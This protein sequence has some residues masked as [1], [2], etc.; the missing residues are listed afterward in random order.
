[1]AQAVM[2]AIEGTV[3]QLYSRSYRAWML[4][5]L[6][7][8]NALNLADRQCMAAV[9][10]AVRLDLRITD[11]QMGILQGFGFAIFYSL[12]GLAI[13]RAAEHFSRTRIIAASIGLF[14]AMVSLCSTA[15][16]FGRLLLFRVGVGVGDAGFGPP[17]A[18]LIGDHY[19]VDRRAAAMTVI[20]LGGPLGAAG[21]ALFGGWMAEHYSWRGAFLTLG[22]VGLGV[23]AIAFLSLREPRRGMSD[24]VA[25]T[26]KPPAT[27]EVL[28]FL[29]SK[30][31][32]RHFLIGCGLAS[33]AMQGIG[34]FFSPFMVRNYHMGSTEAGGLLALVGGIGMASGLSLGGFGVG[35]AGRSDKRWYAW[36]PAATLFLAALFF[37]LG[38]EQPT[39]S[40]A[41]GLLI[42]AHIALFVYYTPTLAIAQNMVGAS[43]RASSGFLVAAVIGLVGIGL[44]PTLVGFLSDA[45]ANH[46]FVLG[47][48]AELCPKGLPRPGAAADIAAACRDASATGLRYAL[49]TTAFVAVWGA[50][51]YFL[52]SREVRADL[53]KVYVP[54]H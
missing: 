14:G 18:S 20:W 12:F 39:P 10:Q 46:S 23:S 29:W 48:Y 38:F 40:R 24:P 34:Q 27:L 42:A 17:V 43:M 44:G 28:K 26:G 16:S 52:A 9:S 1:M 22:L 30:R 50:L 31:S 33:A 2:P 15:V 45:Y 35:R 21:G 5:V 25:A 49:I 6:L 11:A 19:K 47:H 8:M 4:T 53:D 36:A 37:A 7:A 54:R 13:A 51:H 3:G 41:V 32:M